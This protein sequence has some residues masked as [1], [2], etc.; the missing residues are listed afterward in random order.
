MSD[1]RFIVFNCNVPSLFWEGVV[2]GLIMNCTQYKCVQAECD[3]GPYLGFF[4]STMEGVYRIRGPFFGH[5]LG[6][7]GTTVNTQVEYYAIDLVKMPLND[8]W[9][10]IME[11]IKN[12]LI[13]VAG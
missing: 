5:S 10:D 4:P 13:D 1:E 8:K 12:V 9:R 11:K 2:D 3:Q 7:G 6:N